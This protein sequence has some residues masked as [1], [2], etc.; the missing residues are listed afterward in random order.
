MLEDPSESSRVPA[1]PLQT[2]PEFLQSR[3]LFQAPGG[4]GG[5]PSWCP[6]LGLRGS[7]QPIVGS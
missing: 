2:V 7:G 6:R 1:I 4:G 3:G 5:L